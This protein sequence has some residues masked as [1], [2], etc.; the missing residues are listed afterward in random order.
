ME[1]VSLGGE[2]SI[3]NSIILGGAYFFLKDV[4]L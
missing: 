1:V 3:Y 4:M 2:V